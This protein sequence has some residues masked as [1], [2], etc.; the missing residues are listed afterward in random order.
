MIFCTGCGKKESKR[1]F[2]SAVNYKCTGCIAKDHDNHE[3]AINDTVAANS[4]QD[5][6]TIN[7]DCERV[8]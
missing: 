3:H 5:V 1:C 8:I 4:S 7:D 2:I 6:V